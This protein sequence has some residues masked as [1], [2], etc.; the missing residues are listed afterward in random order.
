VRRIER[1]NLSARL[2]QC[3]GGVMWLLFEKILPAEIAS[4]LSGSLQ[5]WR[6]GKHIWRN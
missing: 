1:F 5:A 3:C 6:A 2:G 4:D